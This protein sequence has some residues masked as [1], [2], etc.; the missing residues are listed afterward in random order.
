[1]SYRVF[2][3]PTNFATSTFGW[4][5][6]SIAARLR[7]AFGPSDNNLW[8]F[9]AINPSTG[10]NTTDD[11]GIEIRSTGEVCIFASANRNVE[12]DS[13]FISWLASNLGL[14]TLIH[15][16]L[17]TSRGLNHLRQNGVHARSLNEVLE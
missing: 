12:N 6:K 8:V 13:I 2:T 16:L 3:R 4:L 15:K 10:P 17:V 14:N 5:P 9:K 7:G 1:M 11:F